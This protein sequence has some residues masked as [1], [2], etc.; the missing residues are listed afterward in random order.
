MNDELLHYYERE[1]S[2]LRRTGAQFAQRYPKVAS[3]LRLEATKSDDPHVERLL[4]GFAFLTARLHLKLDDDLPAVG[5]ALLDVVY[6]H[7]TRPVPS[8]ALVQLELDPEQGK[9]TTG[10]R[11]PRETV[12]YSKPVGGIPCKFRTCYETTVWPITVAGAR[13]A[14]PHE[15]SPPL[16]AG[17]AVAVLRLELETLPDLSF[18][19]LELETLRLHL[20]AE[21]NLAGTL[22]E[23]LSNNC[24]EILIRDLAAGS[25]GGAARDPVRLPPTALR[26]VGFE[27]EEGLLPFPKRAF[28]GFRLLQEYFTFPDKFYFL[29]LGG[30]ERVRPAGFGSRVEVLFLISPFERSDRRIMLES[31]VG[32]DTIRLGCTPIVNLFPQTSEP[33]S[34]SQR[35]HEYLL[36]PDA[37]RR[38]A[39]GIYSIEEVS[40]IVPGSPDPIR[41]EP[42]YS[43][44]HGSNGAGR[45]RVYWYATRRPTLWRPEEGTDLYLS[46]A[47]SSARLAYPDQDVV[48]ARLL[49]HNGALPERLPFGDPGGDFQMP[50]SG[51]IRRIVTLVKPTPQI[52]PPLGRSQL[53]RLVSLLSLNYT[54]LHEEGVAGL[55]ELLHLHNFG[56]T[57][58]GGMQIE[59]ITQ[60]RG[61]PSFARIESVHGL[62][63]ARGHRVELE[64]D[65]ENFAGGGIY[66]LASV[67]ERFFGMSVSLNSFCM[68]AV[69]SRQR[70]GVVREWA[71]R[72]GKRPLL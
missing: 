11:V 65:E 60:L 43:L 48:T 25:K 66:L 6:P 24:V 51:P 32:A 38:E 40:G 46:F 39:T 49:C 56:G 31:G 45:D 69:R 34:L 54:S 2:Y 41:F 35:R 29:D 17:G 14:A 22:Y 5:E 26:P 62:T 72:A 13:W 68:L 8:L 10:L 55:R 52:Q 20:S 23:L 59:G 44:R 71:P 58:A 28:P 30:L 12:L 16:R 21:P 47:D 64:F 9:S 19:E 18:A 61:E 15:L 67:L 42:L 50:G 63:F 4:E 7:Y 3:R 37:R 36:V 57:A 70:K 27:E 33:V 1:L 53:W